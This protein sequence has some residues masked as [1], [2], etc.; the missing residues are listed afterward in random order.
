M[1]PS[2]LTLARLEELEVTFKEHGITAFWIGDDEAMELVRLAKLGME[3]EEAKEREEKKWASHT[4]E[5]TLCW[6]KT[7]LRNY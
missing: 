1:T 7:P 5:T 6:C 3:V 4:C 2:T